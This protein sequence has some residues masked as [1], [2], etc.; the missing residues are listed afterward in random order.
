MEVMIGLSIRPRISFRIPKRPFYKRLWLKGTFGQFVELRFF[1]RRAGT[2]SGLK[3]AVEGKA[4]DALRPSLNFAT[5][6]GLYCRKFAPIYS[7]ST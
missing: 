6:A 4:L 5:E 3:N 7:P 1:K 2:V